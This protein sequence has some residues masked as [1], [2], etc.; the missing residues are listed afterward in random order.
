M[1]IVTIEI[2]AAFRAQLDAIEGARLIRELPPDRVVV[3][4][5]YQPNR[6]VTTLHGGLSYRRQSMARRR[7]PRTAVKVRMAVATISKMAAIQGRMW[8]TWG[9][10]EAR[11]PSLM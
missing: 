10:I 8:G 9:T 7:K 4:L 6:A 3:A 1:Y 11:T 2:P 5:R